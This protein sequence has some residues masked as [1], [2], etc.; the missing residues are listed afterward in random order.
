MASFAFGGFGADFEA[1]DYNG[2]AAGIQLTD[3]NTAGGAPGG[4][5]AQQG[6]YAPSGDDYYVYT[7]ADNPFG[8]TAANPTGGDQFVSGPT[9][10]NITTH[11]RGQ[12]DETL[13]AGLPVLY[14]FDFNAKSLLADPALASSN[15]GSFSIQPSNVNLNLLMH[16]RGEGVTGE[17]PVNDPGVNY[18]FSYLGI[19]DA[20]GT[21]SGR[22]YI[23]ATLLE[24]HW[25]RNETIVDFDTNLVTKITLTDLATMGQTTIT[26]EGWYL[27]G[28][29]IRPPENEMPVAFRMFDYGGAQEP[30][31]HNNMMAFDNVVVESIPEP[32]TLCLL[33]AGA[34]SVVST[35]R[36]R[37]RRRVA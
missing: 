36:R 15:A 21:D 5:A 13:T 8:M 29:A 37:R 35:L 17:G 26:P 7:Y 25:Y 19:K 6:W 27:A 3:G 12:H 4:P 24:D 28:G 32:A 14:G 2:S 18:T 16:R 22:Q 1:P 9:V 31:T 30:P 23:S 10:G 33:G 11:A 34:L 20:N